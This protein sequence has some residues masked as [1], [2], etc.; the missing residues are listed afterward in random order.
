MA[1]NDTM[2]D[3]G[4]LQRLAQI[5]ERPNV[6]KLLETEVQRLLNTLPAASS[7][8]TSAGAAETQSS[9]SATATAATTATKARDS[10]VFAAPIKSYGWDQ[11]SNSVKIYVTLDGVG[12]LPKEQVQVTF[13]KESFSLLVENLNGKNH[14]LAVTLGDEIVPEKSTFKIRRTS[15]QVTLH[16]ATPGSWSHLTAKEKKTEEKKKSKMA[17]VGKTPSDDPS[18]GLMNMLKKMYDD[19][20]DDMKRNLSKA[21]T[22]SQDKQARGD[23]GTA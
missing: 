16:K 18:A 10:K 1:T 9:A 12:G 21:W 3:V 11:E 5:A 13:A 17:D 23:F 7:T 19:G 8:N 4:E 15:V 20:D 22:E 2:K 6:K 14:T